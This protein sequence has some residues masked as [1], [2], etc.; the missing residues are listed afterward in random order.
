MSG[1]RASGRDTAGVQNDLH[2]P[3]DERV[4]RILATRNLSI[5]Q[6]S[7]ES[8]RRFGGDPRYHIPHNFY[9]DLR[10]PHYSPQIHHVVALSTVTTRM[11]ATLPVRRTTLLDSGVYDARAT[12]EWFGEA[13]GTLLLPPIAPVSRL[14]ARTSNV[15]IEA[16]C[17][18]PSSSFVYAKVGIEDAFA[19]PDLVPGSVIRADTRRAQEALAPAG[20][21]KSRPLFLIEYSKGFVCCNILRTVRNRVL[22]RSMELP[23]SQVELQLERDVR[24]LGAIDLE[25]RPTVST[26]DF[27]VAADLADDWKPAPLESTLPP[28][29]L[30]RL[31]A[32]ARS[33][34]RLSLREA[35]T[36]SRRIAE[37]LGDHRYF[38]APGSLSDL[39][40]TTVAPRHI[41]KIFTLCSVYSIPF[42]DFL[43][44]LGVDFTSVGTDPMP[45]HLV[46]R[47][48]PERDN[49]VPIPP[50]QHGFISQLMNRFEEIPIFL[51]G[52][53][54]PL[55]SLPD[56]SVRDVYWVGGTRL[57]LHPNL[58]G[59]IFV[60]VNRRRKRIERVQNHPVWLQPLW[61]L[62]R[63]DGSLIVTR[64]TTQNGSLVLHPFSN[65]SARPLQLQNRGEVEVIGKVTAILRAL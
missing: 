17:P 9:F 37:T 26:P 33:R 8:V 41:Q 1:S 57:P 4:R 49:V 52:S 65:T 19:F 36:N 48:S 34:A 53:L 14:L 39:E 7:R 45:D 18:A 43:V 47:R 15:R 61:M 5:S 20:E 58:S 42:R 12:I 60:A 25:L 44:A 46:S 63:R 59:A 35:S 27:Q 22:I 31:L 62:L 2:L 21:S 55:A 3:V 24:I 16:L 13:N 38:C 51:L 54:G 56:I 10:L 30:A 40:S 29:R 6:I 11:M 64:C 50:Q 23:F 28:P 32:N